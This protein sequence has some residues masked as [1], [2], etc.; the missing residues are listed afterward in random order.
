MNFDKPIEIPRKDHFGNNYYEVYSKRLKRIVRVFSSL[1]YANF[2]TLEMNPSVEKFCERPLELEIMVEGQMQKTIFDFW[3]KYKDESEEMQEIQYKDEQNENNDNSIRSQ[4]LI[5]RKKKWCEDNNINFVLRTDE[6]IYSGR[7]YIRNLEYLSAKS[8]RYIPLD[9]NYYRPLLLNSL[10]ENKK[11][12]ISDMIKFEIL[13]S[14]H[15]LDYISY[16]YYE[17]VIAMDIST[18]PI[19]G[20]MEVALWQTSL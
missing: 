12:S 18:R 3:V 1:R 17:G 14:G 16:L 7:F 13:P 15:E 6:D 10:K 4:E 20:K 19:D 11:I 5:R 9:D 2:I 8:R